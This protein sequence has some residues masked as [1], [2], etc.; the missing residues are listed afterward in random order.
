M[1]GDTW[2][3]AFGQGFGLARQ[4]YK[5]RK[6]AEEEENL[7]KLAQQNAGISRTRVVD[8]DYSVVSADPVTKSWHPDSDPAFQRNVSDAAA[9][10]DEGLR[11]LESQ[12]GMASGTVK[13]TQAYGLQ[14]GLVPEDRLERAA[15][16]P[17]YSQDVVER[18]DTRNV[19]VRGRATESVQASERYA[20][21]ADNA[22]KLGLY[23]QAEQY[24]LLADKTALDE[25]RLG[26]ERKRFGWEE[27]DRGDVLQERKLRLDNLKQQLESGQI[28]ID[29]KKRDIRIK[30][31]LSKLA[32]VGTWGELMTLADPNMN[33]GITPTY[34][35]VPLGKGKK[36]V[37]IMYGGKPLHNRVFADLNDAKKMIQ[38][39]ISENPDLYHA[40]Q[41]QEE[42]RQLNRRNIESQ[43][44]ARD[45]E[46]RAK[47]TAA[48]AKGSGAE[49]LTAL[50]GYAATLNT[51]ISNLDRALANDPNNKALKLQRDKAYTDLQNVR[52]MIEKDRLGLGGAPDPLKGIKPG[53]TV[54]FGGVDYVYKGGDTQSQSSYEPVKQTGLSA[55]AAPAEKK[56]TL[57]TP[58]KKE[59][60]R[61]R[62][63]IK[64]WW[65]GLEFDMPR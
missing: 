26:W 41:V 37:V 18:V 19:P 58:S 14:R 38:Q 15:V 29:E 53:D 30:N 23:K 51:E 21:M 63:A 40:Y 61:R 31:D 42:D 64:Q 43:I 56:E 47:M 6:E 65:D 33:D 36:G 60:A 44:S 46:A 52:T 11:H 12:Y 3:S 16:D 28:T 50:N 20:Q 32:K 9:M 10:G 54:K 39:G 2:S 7:K 1:L 8:K 13:P 34:E 35:E 27:S 4:G 45:M 57:F 17:G 48:S 55:P 62:E 24:S 49:K 22:A 5:D 25:E 59:A